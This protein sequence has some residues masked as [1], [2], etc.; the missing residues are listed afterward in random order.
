MMHRI[1][2][3]LLAA[4]AVLFVAAQHY[5]RSVPAWGWALAFSEAA[6]VGGLAD[7]FAVTALFRRPLGL[8]IPHTAIIPTNKDRIADNMARFLSTHF[9]TPAVVARRMAAINLAEVIGKWLADPQKSAEARLRKGA[10]NLA[11]DLLEALDGDRQLGR[12]V[13]RALRH[14]LEE[15]DLAPLLGRLLE[16]AMAEGR[17]RPVLEAGLRW[18]GLALEDNEELLRGVIHARANVILRWTGLDERLS[19]SILDGLYRLLAECI[20]NPDHPM[21]LRFEEGLAKL[22]GDLVTDPKMHD[23]VRRAKAEVLANPAL[24]A[25]MDGL[26]EGLRA[27]MLGAA[28]APGAGLGRGLGLASFGTTLASNRQLQALTNRF[29]RRA[30]AGT[31]SRHAATIVTL[32]SETVKRWD[33]NTISARIEATVGRDLQFIRINGTLVG[34]LVGLAL[35][36]IKSVI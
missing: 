27:R 36:A 35:Y 31:A 23:R 1:A 21:R 29:L 25:W 22:A 24:G 13:K 8:P 33:G 19:N 7:W 9:L 17:H 32:V 10:G 2:T 30:I 3:G 15:L 16:A 14:R 5:A 6:L 26:W 28:G 12:V 34:G 20:V 11:A 18:A 4:M